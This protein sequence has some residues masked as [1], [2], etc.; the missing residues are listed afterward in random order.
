MATPDYSSMTDEELD[1]IINGPT[2]LKM[3]EAPTELIPPKGSV[4][5]AVAQHYSD[6][7]RG[8]DPVTLAPAGM[9]AGFNAIGQGAKEKLQMLLA[10][11]ETEPEVLKQIAADRASLD[12]PS[13]AEPILRRALAI[14][15]RPLPAGHRA[16]VPTLTALGRALAALGRPG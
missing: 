4:G 5:A 6:T 8:M 11:K 2:T 16:M 14:Q 7:A 3:V 1:A 12:G 9:G 13:A 15:R 10:T